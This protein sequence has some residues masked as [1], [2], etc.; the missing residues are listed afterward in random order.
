[1]F[2]LG[3][4]QGDAFDRIVSFVFGSAKPPILIR[5]PFAL[6]DFVQGVL[7][8]ALADQR[9]AG[10]QVGPGDLQVDGRLLIGFV[11]GTQQA[12]CDRFLARAQRLLLF[13]DSVLDEV[14]TVTAAKQ[15]VAKFHLDPHGC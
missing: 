2:R 8:G 5:A 15:S 10:A 1:M 12:L 13:R 4:D 9:V 7:P 14:Q 6:D 11:A 3:F